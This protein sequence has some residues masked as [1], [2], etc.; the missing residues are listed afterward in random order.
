[1]NVTDHTHNTFPSGFQH[2]I[3]TMGLTY[4]VHDMMHAVV[5]NEHTIPCAKI[6]Q[7]VQEA[8]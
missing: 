5:R 4:S 6:C 1:M 8:V 3:L 2:D 7:A